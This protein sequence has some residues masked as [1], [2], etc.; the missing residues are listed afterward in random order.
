MSGKVLAGVVIGALLIAGYFYWV[1][2]GKQSYAAVGDCVSSP[3]QGRLVQVGCGSAGALKVL[4]RFGGDDSNQCD[5][6]AATTR[7]FVEYPT[8]QA[9]FVLCA[10]DAG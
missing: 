9:A 6:V 7:A 1:E 8:S 5:A 4:A 2:Q 3:G 10:G